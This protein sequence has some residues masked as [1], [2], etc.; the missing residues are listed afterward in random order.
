MSFRTKL[1][2]SYFLVLLIPTLLACA[3]AF[4][5]IRNRA[6]DES[7][8]DLKRNLAVQ[9]EI[10]TSRIDS[11][12]ALA[13]HIQGSEMFFRWFYL[14]LY[15][16]AEYVVEQT[17]DVEPLLQ[18]LYANQPAIASINFY[19]FNKRIVKGQYF[20]N[21]EEVVGQDWF[22]ELRQNGAQVGFY[23]E[24]LHRTR[25]R[26]YELPP[27]TDVVSIALPLPPLPSNEATYFEIEVYPDRLFEFEAE[28]FST[29]EGVTV[30]L[31]GNGSPVLYLSNLP[32][33][34]ELLE[35]LSKE[36]RESGTATTKLV[37]DGTPYVISTIAFD[38]GGFLLVSAVKSKALSTSTP[39]TMLVLLVVF[40][41]GLLILYVLS[42]LLAGVL[43]RRIRELVLAVRKVHDGDY[44]VAVPVRG[45]D[46]IDELAS[47]FNRMS[48][49]IHELIHTVYET[50]LS[51]REAELA[52]LHAQINPHFIYNVLETV[53]ML[54]ELHDEVEIAHSLTSLGHIL[55]YNT[56]VDARFTRLADDI[57]IVQDYVTVQNLLFDNR[58]HLRC[59]IAPELSDIEIPSFVLQ[60]IVENS[61]IHGMDDDCES[62]S[63]QVS[64]RA[65]SQSIVLIVEDDGIGT[66]EE[67]VASARERFS[68]VR[69]DSDH[70]ESSYNGVGL[71][72]IN[73][74]I[75][76]Y[77]GNDYG[78]A[79]ESIN[80]GG[81]R[82]IIRLP[83]KSENRRVPVLTE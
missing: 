33:Y 3:Y 82:T 63:I 10:F 78:I 64:V 40:I 47:D 44:E 30:V 7:F 58:I 16:D 65:D 71:A 17:A 35:R 50:K 38:K 72:N 36:V 26:A 8:A 57:A 37:F 13:M 70:V 54:A 31:D 15:D 25:S 27:E 6:R 77:Y 18:A 46:E 43:V 79:I 83:A 59:D 12:E 19:T 45:N 49:K 32:L 67:H 51:Q 48:A 1:L 61:I 69:R 55:R 56:A 14:N 53:K 20:Y 9:E 28:L 5:T 2:A 60:P 34:E 23:W 68:R 29:Y 22:E 42:E 80:R 62:L 11:V 73:N 4:L 76:L 24:G 81:F 52:T 75:R 41:A 21:A 39:R 74:R 66:S